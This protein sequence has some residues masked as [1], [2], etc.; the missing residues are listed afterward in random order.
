MELS[1]N[2]KL[3]QVARQV[4]HIVEGLLGKDAQD[5]TSAEEREIRYSLERYSALLKPWAR[6]VAR[7][8]LADV[9]R[10]NMKAWK[11]VG[12]EMGRAL[13]IEIAQAP[14]GMLYEALMAE[15]VEL[16]TSLPTKAAQ[17]VHKLVT[18]GMSE[19]T[20]AADIAKEILRTGHVTAS[21]ATLIARTETARA[22]SSF[23]QVRAVY[24]GSE[25]YIWR[26]SQ[27]ADVRETH[28][29]QDGRYIR[30]SSPPKTDPGL[31]PYHAGCGP[32][33]RCYPEPIFPVF[34]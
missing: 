22:S 29:E 8:M 25:G 30:W 5:I 4:G 1:Y 14:T 19:S 6:S 28:K 12:K 9:D 11:E 34:Q 24:A 27:D 23:V 32:N 10:R 31:E 3:R 16:I 2:A 26:S 7:Y 21:R 18:E 13:R 17:R 20:R 15:Q 33:C